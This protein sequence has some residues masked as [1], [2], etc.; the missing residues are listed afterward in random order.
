MSRSDEAETTQAIT[1]ALQAVID[2]HAEAIRAHAK[3]TITNILEIGRRLAEVKRSLGYGNWL[4][5]LEREFRWS[6]DTAERFIALHALQRQIPN[7]SELSLPHRT[8]P[9]GPTE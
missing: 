1:A 8:G 2:E 7:V 5:W 6:E 9:Y 4:S 3:R